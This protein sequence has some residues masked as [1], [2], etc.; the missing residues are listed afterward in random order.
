MS[1]DFSEFRR[2]LGAE[3]LSSDD[4]L[5]RARKSG[6]EFEQAAVEAEAFEARL[7]R[8]LAI[9]VPDNLLDDLVT[10]SSAQPENVQTRRWMPVALAASVLIAVG[11]AGMVWQMNRGYSTVGEYLAAHYEYDGHKLVAK[12]DGHVAGNVKEILAKFEVEATDELT[13]M[14]GFIKFC[15]TR[16]GKGAHM[17]LNT[18]QGPVTVIFMPTETVTDGESLAFGDMQARLIALQSGS[19]AVIASGRQDVSRYF[20]MV[21]D[22]IVPVSANI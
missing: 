14:V 22:S 3:P 15:P 1:M 8:A 4:E 21:R 2:R 9:P 12:A 20:A 17:V 18:E 10:I 19:A 5:L 11:A 6:P 16:D 13:G 7:E